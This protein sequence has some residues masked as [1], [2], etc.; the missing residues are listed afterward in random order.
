MINIKNTIDK[1]VVLQFKG[2]DVVIPASGE[3]EL[4]NEA[5]E[6]VLNTLAFCKEEK[7]VVKASVPKV[8]V[9]EKKEEKEKD[10]KE[11]KK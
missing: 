1:E 2:E 7:K 9:E 6:F 3:I 11:S 4:P 8:P 10:T 5:A